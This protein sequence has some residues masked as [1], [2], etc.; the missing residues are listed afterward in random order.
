MPFCKKCGNQIPDEAKFCSKCGTSQ[1]ASKPSARKA[2]AKKDS[3]E[4]ASE[5][6]VEGIERDPAQK[7]EQSAADYDFIVRN[8]AIVYTV[9]GL[10]SYVLMTLGATYIGLSQTFGVILCVFAIIAAVAFLMWGLLRFS[11][12]GKKSD[13]SAR[14]GIYLAVSI[15]GFVFVIMSC[16][17]IFIAIS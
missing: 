7:R 15:I 17:A 13:R 3:E 1:N 2:P 8:Y 16:I 4:I 12:I 5:T 11:F 14:D 9:L 6:A 10:M